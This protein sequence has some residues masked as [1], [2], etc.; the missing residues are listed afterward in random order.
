M[1]KPEA[2]AK[3]NREAVLQEGDVP[4]EPRMA[5]AAARMTAHSGAE[6]VSAFTR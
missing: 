5:E 4:P 3:Q 1:Q 2:S 6:R